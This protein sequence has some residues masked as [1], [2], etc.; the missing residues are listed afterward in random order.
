MFGDYPSSMKSRVGNRLQK[1]TPSEAALVK[2]SGAI[3]LPF[4]GTKAIVERVSLA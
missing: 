4:N 3:T 2:D 1:F